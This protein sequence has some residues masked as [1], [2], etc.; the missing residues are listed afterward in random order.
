[1]ANQLADA[2]SQFKLEGRIGGGSG[3]INHGGFKPVSAS[4]SLSSAPRPVADNHRTGGRSVSAPT[5]YVDK[6]NPSSGSP[7]M[8]VKTGTDDSDWEEF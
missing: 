7:K 5:G 6:P 1:Q 8:T 2:I 4:A 3:N